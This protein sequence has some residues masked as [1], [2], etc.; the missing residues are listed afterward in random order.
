MHSHAAEAT[1]LGRIAEPAELAG[2]VAF[3]LSP[4]ASFVTGADLVADGG[5]M[6]TLGTTTPSG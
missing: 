2:I 4:A 5:H 6:A 1:A 3:L